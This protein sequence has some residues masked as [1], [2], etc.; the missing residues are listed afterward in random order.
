MGI[1]WVGKDKHYYDQAGFWAAARYLSDF[2]EVRLAACRAAVP[3][4][5]AS[6]VDVG[7]G[8][9]AFLVGL[10]ATTAG[11]VHLG[12][13]RS[14][15]AVKA[16]LCRSP[17]FVGEA[18]ALPFADRSVDL[19]SALDVVEHF[20]FRSYE[21]ALA[22]MCRVAARYI[23]INVPYREHR[24]HA[25]CPYCG[26]RFDPHY[27]MRRF[28]RSSFLGL[29]SGF[30]LVRFQ[31]VSREESVL[32]AAVRPFRTRVFGGFP[33]HAVCPQCDFSLRDSDT[34]PA[35]RGGARERIRQMVR[36]LPKVKMP[37][38]AVAL[39]RRTGA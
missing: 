17:L 6:H 7:A 34:G 38:E 5:I 4:D 18:T 39:Y 36:A 26:C 32:E 23:L 10:E 13:E 31:T 30:E 9:G 15:V 14:P 35:V 12:I 37:V 27:H 19:L 1:S 8:N 24:L 22:E 21:S 20:P 28:D 33:P 29:L 16:A 11:V 25:V 2:E 3:A